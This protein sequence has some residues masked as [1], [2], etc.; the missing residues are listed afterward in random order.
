VDVA[1]EGQNVGRNKNS[2]HPF[3]PLGAKCALY[4][5]DL[6]LNSDI[7]SRCDAAVFALNY[8]FCILLSWF[9]V[10]YWLV[11]INSGGNIGYI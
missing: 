10:N 7:V 4:Y 2:Q 9:V 11:G 3:A 1:P 5:F 8:S 6:V